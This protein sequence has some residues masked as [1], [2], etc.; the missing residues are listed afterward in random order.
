MDIN[1]LL[2]E[3]YLIN[4]Q[5]GYYIEH[6]IIQNKHKLL[7]KEKLVAAFDFDNTLIN[8]DIEEAFFAMMINKGFKT[9]LK[10]EKYLELSKNGNQ[11]IAYTEIKKDLIKLNEEDIK[12]IFSEIYKNL[13]K[14]IEFKDGNKVY[15]IINPKPNILMKILIEI[16]KQLEFKIY[17]VSASLKS[18]ILYA[19]KHWFHLDEDKILAS[20]HFSDNLNIIYGNEKEAILKKNGV[21]NLLISGGDNI[22]D[23]HF[24]NMTISNGLCLIRN[25][26]NA[27]EIIP[28]LN[29]DKNIILF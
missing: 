16:L 15:Q 22:G 25:T 27:N 19:N 10:W 3:I 13:N 6:L 5:V 12:T 24:L 23:I 11:Q 1:I 7:K 9:E 20:C 26:S 29:K 18:L 14:F 28:K 2:N 21:K 17:I 4:K 8:G